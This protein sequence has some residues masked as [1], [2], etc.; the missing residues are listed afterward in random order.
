VTPDKGRPTAEG[1]QSAAAAS[2]V[3]EP[4]ADPLRWSRIEEVF[5]ES[6]DKLPERRSEHLMPRGF[7]SQTTVCV[8]PG[9]MNGVSALLSRVYALSW[10][11]S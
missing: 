1:I 11:M 8:D 5:P 4:T 9:S 7:V 6:L 2:P 10:P 3:N